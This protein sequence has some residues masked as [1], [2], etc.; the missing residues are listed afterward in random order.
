MAYLQTVGPLRHPLDYT[1]RNVFFDSTYTAEYLTTHRDYYLQV[2]Q[3]V[4]V[5]VFFL[6]FLF[7][8]ECK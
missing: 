2:E 8:F 3:V 4:V 7:V 1:N 6:L 5:V